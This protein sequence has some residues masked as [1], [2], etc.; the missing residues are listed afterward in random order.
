MIDYLSN[1]PYSLYWIPCFISLFIFLFVEDRVGRDPIVSRGLIRHYQS[2]LRELTKYS[3]STIKV[4]SNSGS[5][6]ND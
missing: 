6:K 1:S 2:F 4:S 3:S 5:T